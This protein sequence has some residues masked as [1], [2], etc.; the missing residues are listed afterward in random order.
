MRLRQICLVADALEETLATL[1]ELLASPVMYRDPEVAYFGLANGLIMSGGD[2]IEV[3][4]PL[5]D[6]HDTAAGRQLARTGPGFYMAIFQC[7][8][9]AP[10]CA[11][12]QAQGVRPEFSYDKDG[13]YATHFHPGDFGG[14]IVSV[15]SM[16]GEDWQSP[17]AA[18]QWTAWPPKGETPN[19]HTPVGALAGLTLTTPDPTALAAH[20]AGLLQRPLA[21]DEVPLDRATLHFKAGEGRAQVRN[22]HL[23]AGRDTVADICARARDMGLPVDENR[24]SF[25]GVNWCFH[26]P[27]A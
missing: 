25:G 10:I 2:F 20:W 9:A 17:S 19:T 12:I 16:G 14:A 13:V 4:S 21:Q 3:V 15:D 8:D 5:P 6:R 23:S 18:W 22:I 24:V 11:H 26:P 1:K 27:Q 7:A